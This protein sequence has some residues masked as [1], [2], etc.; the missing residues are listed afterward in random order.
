MPWSGC[1]FVPYV[2]ETIIVYDYYCTVLYCTVL[3]CTVLYSMKRVQQPN[4]TEAFPF[5]LS[6]TY[7]KTMYVL[8]PIPF[9]TLTHAVKNV[10][11]TNI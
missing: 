10:R 2:D 5:V 1:V 3:Y 11:F 8:L 6:L 7:V 9:L 4:E